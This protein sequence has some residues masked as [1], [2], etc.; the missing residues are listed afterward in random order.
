MTFE[1]PSRRR[2]NAVVVCDNAQVLLALQNF[3][4]MIEALCQWLHTSQD[5]ILRYRGHRRFHG[6]WVE[7][8]GASVLWEVLSSDG[9]KM[10]NSKFKCII[11]KYHSTVWTHHLDQH[12][13]SP[14]NCKLS[15]TSSCCAQ[16]YDKVMMHCSWWSHALLLITLLGCVPCAFSFCCLLYT[17]PSPRD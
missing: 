3:G 9:Q 12:T 4:C 6:G 11:P 14:K 15:I 17:S 8:S 16:T 2:I 13:T 1:L 7:V 5:M 10:T